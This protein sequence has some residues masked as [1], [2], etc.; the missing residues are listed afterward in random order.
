M[1]NLVTPTLLRPVGTFPEN[2]SRPQ[3]PPL[4]RSPIHGT[5]G[6]R[7]NITPCAFLS[8]SASTQE[9][10]NPKECIR[11]WRVTQRKICFA[12]L[13]CGTSGS[14]QGIC[15]GAHGRFMGEFMPIRSALDKQRRPVVGSGVPAAP[16]TG[17]GGVGVKSPAADFGE[18]R[19][20]QRSPAFARG[21][22]PCRRPDQRSQ[23]RFVFPGLVHPAPRERRQ[24]ESEG[25]LLRMS[26]I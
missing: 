15:A 8:R 17:A 3:F 24:S 25:I 20:T 22:H 11:N 21:G 18:T 6:A 19:P 23:V 12:A 7:S 9:T 26:L 10:P 4:L 2:R 14:R 16:L 1:R 5:G 13:V